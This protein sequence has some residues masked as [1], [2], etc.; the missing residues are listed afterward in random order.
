MSSNLK[1]VEGDWLDRPMLSEFRAWIKDSVA[2]RMEAMNYPK[3]QALNDA[4]N[5]CL[6]RHTNRDYL[7]CSDKLTSAL[8][9]TLVY[10]GVNINDAIRL[11]WKWSD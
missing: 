7:T 3:I 4:L 5:E 11:S 2:W 8:E 1:C 6:F 9:E 10:F